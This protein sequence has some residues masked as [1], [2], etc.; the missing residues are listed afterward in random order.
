MIQPPYGFALV[1][2][3]RLASRQGNGFSGKNLSSLK[4]VI[5]SLSGYTPFT[6]STNTVGYFAAI[7]SSARAGRNHREVESWH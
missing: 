1:K 3:N 2:K 4:K 6:P 7:A 5:Q